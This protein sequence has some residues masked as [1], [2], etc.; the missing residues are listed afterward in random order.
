MLYNH[1]LV[2]F[3]EFNGYDVYYLSNLLNDP[4]FCIKVHLFFR[5]HGLRSA[6]SVTVSGS[7]SS[8]LWST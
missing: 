3:L 4:F 2:S 8:H 6:Q 5:L 1:V 7:P